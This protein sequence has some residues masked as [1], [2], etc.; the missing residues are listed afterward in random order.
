EGAAR[1]GAAGREKAWRAFLAVHVEFPAHPLADEAGRRAAAL[2]PPSASA[3][4]RRAGPSPPESLARAPAPAH[5]PHLPQAADELERLPPDL[6]PPLRAER[7][8]QLGMTKYHMRRD[9]GRAASLLL[10]AVDGLAGEKQQSAAFHGT[11]ALSRA[12]RDDEAIA[13]YRKFVARF[14]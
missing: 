2:A 9:Y 4:P 12:D 5:G 3:S 14:P 10:G 13:G 8:F 11:R 7:D 1:A 6:P